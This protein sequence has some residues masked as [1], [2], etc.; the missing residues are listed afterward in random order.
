[1]KATAQ[2]VGALF[3]LNRAMRQRMTKTECP[4]NLNMHQMHALLS[5]QEHPRV[6]MSDIAR[7]MHVSQA[8]ATPLVAKLVRL[9]LV[10]RRGDRANRKVIRVSLTARGASILKKALGQ[11]HRQLESLF[12]TLKPADQRTM[13]R[14]LADLVASIHSVSHP[15]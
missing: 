15:L 3:E 6:T 9:G 7:M 11:C 5:I 8:T 2:I 10:A 14:I 4:G 12:S 13:A 1:M